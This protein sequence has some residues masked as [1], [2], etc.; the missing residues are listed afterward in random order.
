MPHVFHAGPESSG[1]GPVEESGLGTASCHVL[2][3]NIDY[4]IL[5]VFVRMNRLPASA[6]TGRIRL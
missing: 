6:K 4:I 1:G 5:P 3:S 2:W